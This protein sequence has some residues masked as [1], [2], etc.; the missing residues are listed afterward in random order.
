MQVN[1]RCINSTR[2]T[3]SIFQ[4]GICLHPTGSLRMYLQWSSC[5][6]HLLTHQVRATV[7]NWS[8]CSC[9]FV[10]W[11]QFRALI[12]SLDCWFC[13]GA[14]RLVLFQNFSDYHSPQP[15]TH[16]CSSDC[17]DLSQSHGPCHSPDPES[18]PGV[19]GLGTWSGRACRRS[20][21]SGRS[22]SHGGRSPGG[23][24]ACCPGPLPAAASS[25]A[26]SA[27]PAPPGLGLLHTGT[28]GEHGMSNL[29]SAE[30]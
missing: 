10:W 21:W 4:C 26:S 11:S 20:H 8:L 6:L 5:T 22:G 17:E 30:C 9:V 28:A 12:N 27:V 2:G 19:H 14:L 13:T 24:A 3:F 29:Y 1:T 7:G 16:L 18:A 25:S 15:D 23:G